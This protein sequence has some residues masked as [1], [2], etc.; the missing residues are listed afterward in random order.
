MS[1]PFLGEIRPVAYNFA[2]LNWATCDGQLLPISENQA[3]F[4]LL[5]NSY[6]GDARTTYGLPNLKGRTPIHTG[7]YQYETTLDY[8]RGNFGGQD[9]VT[10]TTSQMPAHRHV[11]NAT[12]QE[13]DTPVIYSPTQ[14]NNMLAVSASASGIAYYT[15]DSASVALAPD[16]VSSSGQGQSHYNVQPSLGLL[17][18]IAMKGIF[19]PRN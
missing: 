17:F 19:P 18:T 4:A 12:A 2:P 10:L 16:T 11:F 6:G 8:E 5:G 9:Y 1:E 14:T 3:L 13:G 7:T 15:S